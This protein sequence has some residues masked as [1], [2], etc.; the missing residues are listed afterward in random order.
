MSETVNGVTY[1]WIEYVEIL[2]QNGEIVGLQEVSQG[3]QKLQLL[4]RF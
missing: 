2:E 1:R 4:L 3:I